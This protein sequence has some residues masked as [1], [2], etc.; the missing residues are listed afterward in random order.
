MSYREN[1]AGER[2]RLIELSVVN[3]ILQLLA[4]ILKR[5]AT[6]VCQT[7]DS[8]GDFAAVGL[9]NLDIASLLELGKVGGQIAFGEFR[10]AL[11]VEE[12]GVFHSIK[13]G[14]DHQP[15]RFVDQPV[16]ICEAA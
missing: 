6:F 13:D 9:F 1:S 11:Q 10:L 2:A 15:S 8:Q 7:A 5:L 16:N 3:E 14:D 12:I 4:I